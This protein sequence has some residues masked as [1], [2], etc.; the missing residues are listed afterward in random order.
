MAL[1]AAAGPVVTRGEIALVLWVFVGALVQGV[2]GLGFSLVAA[3]SVVA[4]VPGTAGVG[5]V[6]LLAAAQNSVIL[7]R[8]RGAVQAREVVRMA[9]LL[10][11]GTT[12]GL[13]AGALLADRLRPLVVAVSSLVSIGYLVTTRRVSRRL[14]SMAL[15]L[16]GA[17]VNS[18]AGVGGPPLSS[19]LVSRVHDPGDYIKTQQAVFLGL[20]LA[21]LPLLGVVVPSA[22]VAVAAAVG[23]LAG[24]LLGLSIRSRISPAHART[25]AVAAIVVVAVYAMVAALVEMAA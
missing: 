12:V 17:T 25:T 23:L 14:A 8:A 5:T 4:L 13:V 15:P 24:S 11:V 9:P 6:N 2:S 20:N 1:R 21:S 19:Y 10:V 22:V 3:P 16:W 7:W 18:L